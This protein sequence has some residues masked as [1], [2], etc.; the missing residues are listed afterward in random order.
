MPFRSAE[1]RSQ[2]YH[3]G[4]GVKD[5]GSMLKSRCTFAIVLA[6]CL[7]AGAAAQ[8]GDKTQRPNGGQQSGQA[9]GQPSPQGQQPAQGQQ[10]PQG[11][12]PV[13]GQ[14]PQGPTFRGGINFVRVDVIVTDKNAQTVS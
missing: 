12:Q 11:Q 8:Q 10:T 6:A 14:S 13:Q 4:Q 1:A 3:R 5:E 9:Q 7:T 2:C